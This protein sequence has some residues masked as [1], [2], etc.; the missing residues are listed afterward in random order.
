M[1]HYNDH[2]DE[3]GVKGMGPGEYQDRADEFLGAQKA[4][5][6][7]ECVRSNGDTVRFK[8][9][10]QEFGILSRS[11][12]IRT[13][14]KPDPAVHGRSTNIAYFNWECKRRKD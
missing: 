14:F 8:P 9:A 7:L 1:E 4:Q 2:V 13:Y 3:F 12:F 5:G 10:T 6:V 11:G